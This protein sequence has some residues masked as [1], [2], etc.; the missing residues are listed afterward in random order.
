VEVGA[1][2]LNSLAD[3]FEGEMAELDTPWQDGDAPEAPEGDSGSLDIDISSDF[4]DLLLSEEETPLGEEG[5]DSQQELA[6]LFG[7]A[8]LDSAAETTDELSSAGTAVAATGADDD[9]ADLFAIGD[10]SPPRR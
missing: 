9:M 6:D 2:E 7:D 10:E 8:V 4:S 3:L 1:A 5:M